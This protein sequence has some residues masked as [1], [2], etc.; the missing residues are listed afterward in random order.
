AIVSTASVTARSSPHRPRV[1]PPLPTRD[2]VTNSRPSECVLEDGMKRNAF[3]AAI[4]AGG[5]VL[6]TGVAG[7]GSNPTPA[8]AKGAGR[9]CAK[10][11]VLADPTP[12]SSA[13]RSEATGP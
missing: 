11:V 8:S 4:V 6:Y 1:R 2:N 10:T 5:L 7:F 13:A 3:G 12:P 9:D